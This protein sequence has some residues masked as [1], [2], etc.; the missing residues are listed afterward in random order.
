MN[1]VKMAILTK[2]NLHVQGNP[3]QNPMT[4]ITETEKSALKFIWKHKRLKI[5]N[6]NQKEQHWR[7]H[8]T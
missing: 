7:Y 4:F 2:S 3:Y 5:D 6:T 8:N 1:T